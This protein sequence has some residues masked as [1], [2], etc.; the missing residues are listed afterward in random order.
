MNTI[1]TPDFQVA[2]ANIAALVFPKTQFHLLS[3]K[4]ESDNLAI[5]FKSQTH[6]SENFRLKFFPKI[7]TL[8]LSGYSQKGISHLNYL[9]A[10]NYNWLNGCG[11]K[12]MFPYCIGE[13]FELLANKF[14]PFLEEF[15]I[16]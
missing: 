4:I 14:Y 12:I 13:K 16:A 10:S 9:P 6:F 15:F 11:D 3:Q 8:I 2:A 5:T 1:L 7:R